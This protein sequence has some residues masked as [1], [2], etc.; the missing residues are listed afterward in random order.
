[1]NHRPISLAKALL[2]SL[3]FSKSIKI[4]LISG[5]PYVQLLAV[6]KKSGTYRSTMSR[7]LKAGYLRRLDNSL[8]LTELGSRESLF[9]F[10]NAESAL[11][12]NNF[13]Q[14]WDGAWR[15]LFFDI[16]ESKR[17]YRDY[18][19][20]VLKR[21]GFKELQRSIWVYPYPVPAF[22]KELVFYKEIGSHARFV[23]TDSLENDEDLKKLFNLP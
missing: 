17:K 3:W 12:K 22:L 13:F 8:F 7:L 19:R 14:K 16:P 2:A 10:I 20:R 21:V 18:L 6:A 23:T 1:M 11:F 9:A 4:N 5:H 15:I